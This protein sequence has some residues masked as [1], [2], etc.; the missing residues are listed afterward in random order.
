[1]ASRGPRVYG[2]ASGSIPRFGGLRLFPVLRSL[3]RPC[4]SFLFCIWHLRAACRPPSSRTGGVTSTA[5][6]VRGLLVRAPYICG[7]R[8]SGACTMRYAC[9]VSRFETP[10]VRSQ[11]HS[12]TRP[13]LWVHP[14]PAAVRFSPACHVL[15]A[16]RVC[17]L[18]GE[19]GY[20]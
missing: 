14:E 17:V 6:E 5:A 15:I 16:R 7:P 9:S 13:C 18:G 19:V 12:A 20:A 8:G 10:D 3:S 2:V 11:P 4:F 1:M